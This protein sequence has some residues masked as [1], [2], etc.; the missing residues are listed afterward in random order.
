MSKIS[1]NILDEILQRC[2]ITEVI[3]NYIPLKKA[4]RNFKALCP[5]HHEKT[6]S[7]I[8]SPDKQ[9]F[10]CFGCGVGGDVF[11]FV[12]KY[13]RMEFPEAVH[14][15]AKKAGVELLLQT[16]QNHTAKPSNT[17]LLYKINELAAWY[18]H[19]NLLKT[20]Q[21]DK[22]RVYLKNR[23]ITNQT[24]ENFRIGYAFDLWDGVLNFLSKKGIS[25]KLILQSGLVIKTAQNSFYD[26]FRDRI[27]FPIFNSQSKIVGFGGR[28]LESAKKQNDR[29]DE[30]PKYINS[31]ETHI[32]IKSKNLY[33]FNFSKRFIQEEDFCIIVE[34]YLD[35]ISPFQQGIK[36]L[37]ASLGTAF[38]IEQAR[39]LRRYTH[40]VVIIF[41]ADV[42]G[43]EAALRSLDLLIEEG[44]NVRIVTLKTGF[45][46]DSYV[47][48]FGEK[49]FRAA[50]NN[51]KSLF[52]YKLSLLSSKFNKDIPEG[53]AKIATEMLG[54]IN[55]V[56]NAILRSTYVKKLSEYLSVSEEVVLIELKRI[57]T[58][59]KSFKDT[60]KVDSL[61]LYK[62]TK[63]AEKML[64][65][66]LFEDA[67]LIKQLK[68]VIHYTEFSD[69]VAQK[70]VKHL[71]DNEQEQLNP[72]T[73][74]KKLGDEQINSFVCNL[75]VSDLGIKDRKRS[76]EDCVKKIKKDKIQLRL[77]ALQEQ[78]HIAERADKD[79]LKSLLEEYHCLKREQRSYEK[80]KEKGK[81]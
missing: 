76:F 46:P 27:I 43:Q 78:V 8:V 22:A 45:D 58:S 64:M 33:G 31:P 2:D 26:R 16:E 80:N 40:N 42:A 67:R 50:V 74:L 59:F 35:F 75:L 9:I 55:K 3:Q 17:S 61:S 47:R 63:A 37:V 15:L 1:D 19:Q 57:K 53:K 73:I 20:Q 29:V 38:T 44:M 4:G 23:G 32:Y 81:N 68:E 54:T 14:Y 70:I 5:F 52:D 24:I 69:P 65:S 71:F 79:K 7:F 72:A 12:M 49:K 25:D 18:F 56:R 21:A 36:N 28:I 41:D 10:H 66:L 30:S 39:L 11:A 13:E 62:V 60:D 48:Q 77:K 6:P 51:A 34:G